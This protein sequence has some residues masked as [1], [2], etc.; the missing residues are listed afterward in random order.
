MY[1]AR[2][3][4]RIVTACVG[5]SL[6]SLAVADEDPGGRSI[7]EP[8]LL[9]AET[10]APP[11]EIF[12]YRVVDQE[13]GALFEVIARDLGMRS[14]VSDKVFGSI[15]GMRLSGN[16]DEV[17]DAVA[18][19]LGLDW[20][21]YN[22][23]LYISNR[24]EALTRIVR[25]EGPKVE[26]VMTVLLESGLPLGKLKITPASANMALSLSG[27]P[28]LLALAEVMI[29]GI[30]PEPTQATEKPATRVVTIRRGNDAEKIYLP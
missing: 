23:V 4:G 1:G 14:V 21:A 12:D 7:S 8:L 2:A 9:S 19:K 24:S 3:Y 20:F 26:K 6:A 25:L 16:R 29:E 27:P 11:Q 30:P 28:K 18:A 17:L 5:V 10:L 15:T 13:S 22:E